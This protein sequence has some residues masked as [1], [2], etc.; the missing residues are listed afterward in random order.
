[1]TNDNE[2][3][4][5]F[6]LFH[7]KESAEQAFEAAL[8]LGY[9]PDEI[10]VIMAEESRTNYYSNDNH[11]E[12]DAAKNLAVGG[13]LGGTIGGTIGA[14]IAL[15]TNFALPGLGLVMVGPLVG[16]GG[17]Y[18][19]LLGSLMGWGTED[20]PSNP[21]EE[22]LKKGEIMLLVNEREGM[23]SLQE[24]WSRISKSTKS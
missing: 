22:R 18:G 2:E 8:Q 10:S 19:G 20:N 16:A 9:K 4:I 24:V 11:A 15:G 7:N 13:V 12:E 23:G 17:V 14:L 6:E 3:H 5:T 1:M 21:Y